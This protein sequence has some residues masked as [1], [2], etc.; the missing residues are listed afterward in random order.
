M[1]SQS[2]TPSSHFGLWIFQATKCGTRCVKPPLWSGSRPRCRP[3]ASGPREVWITGVGILSCLGEGA[4]AHWRKLTEAQPSA[5]AT[6]FAPFV[7][8][9]LAPTNFDAQ[10]P[11]K[12]DQRQ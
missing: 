7:V 11:K 4:N 5:D 2:V 1:A 6:T 8:H 12:G 9:A 10:I 3:M